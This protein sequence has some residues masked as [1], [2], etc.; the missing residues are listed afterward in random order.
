MTLIEINVSQNCIIWK[1]TYT[2]LQ[3]VNYTELESGHQ[4]Y[5]AGRYKTSVPGWQNLIL[6]LWGLFKGE[7]E[8]SLFYYKPYLL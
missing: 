5:N 7:I 4:S 1:I 2:L 8:M 6:K 3:A